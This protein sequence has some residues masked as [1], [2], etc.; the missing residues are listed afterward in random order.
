MVIGSFLSEKS[1]SY[2]GKGPSILPPKFE[3]TSYESDFL[4]ARQNNVMKP[5][6]IRACW[7]KKHGNIRLDRSLQKRSQFRPIGGIT[8]YSLIGPRRKQC[9]GS[10][11]GASQW[12]W[13]ESEIELRI[14]SSVDIRGG[15]PFLRRRAEMHRRIHYWLLPVTSVT[16]RRLALPAAVSLAARNIR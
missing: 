6:G 3:T 9:R 8:K 5:A 10:I 2:S 12:A 15:S 16:P 11:N 14:Q 4:R 13:V 7:N 1:Q